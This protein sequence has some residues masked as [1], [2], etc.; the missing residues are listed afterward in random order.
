MEVVFLA[1]DPASNKKRRGKIN[2]IG[3]HRIDININMLQVFLHK[4][5]KQWSKKHSALWTNAVIH[6]E[7]S[8]L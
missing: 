4:V 5:E 8:T 7:V 3:G 2:E 1:R 6:L